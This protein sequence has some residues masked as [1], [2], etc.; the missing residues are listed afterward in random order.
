MSPV[1]Y[2]SASR[3]TC[4]SF[5]SI[6]TSIP[7]STLTAYHRLFGRVILGPLLL[8][9]ATLYL[10]FFAQSSH[11]DYPSLLAKRF[12][13]SDVQW[14]FGALTVVVALVLLFTRPFGRRGRWTSWVGGS[15][16]SARRV[17]YIGHLMLVGALYGAAWCHVKQARPFVVES[18]VG[19]L[20]NVGCWLLMI[21]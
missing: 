12:E 19:A 21:G 14:G 11:P 7:Q 20:V 16:R 2:I 13:D 1:S 5:L 3:P 15:V 4:P 9:H 10:S 18:V 17:F 8:G 6:L